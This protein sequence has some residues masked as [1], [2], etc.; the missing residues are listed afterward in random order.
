[1]GQDK[2]GLVSGGVGEEREN[3]KPKNFMQRP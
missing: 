2:N 3:T 1:M